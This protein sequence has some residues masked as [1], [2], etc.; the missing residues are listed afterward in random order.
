MNRNVIIQTYNIITA[1]IKVVIELAGECKSVVLRSVSN[2]VLIYSYGM[3]FYSLQ[4]YTVD[5]RLLSHSCI[6]FDEDIY[7]KV[8]NVIVYILLHARQGSNIIYSFY[9]DYKTDLFLYNYD[10]DGDSYWDSFDSF[11]LNGYEWFDRDNDRIG[12]NYDIYEGD[13]AKM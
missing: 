1:K 7:N 8:S 12:D 5:N 10:K 6:L 3:K 11:P 13:D 2:N 4:I 9:N